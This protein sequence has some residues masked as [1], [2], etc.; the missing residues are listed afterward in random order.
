MCI[1][2]GGDDGIVGWSACFAISAVWQQVNGIMRHFFNYVNNI[3][4]YI[5]LNGAF[6]TCF[7]LL[8]TVKHFLKTL[9]YVWSYWAFIIC[10]CLSELNQYSVAVC[11]V[12]CSQQS[13]VLQIML[14]QVSNE[15]FCFQWVAMW[16]LYSYICSCIMYKGK[17]SC[18]IVNHSCVLSFKFMYDLISIVQLIVQLRICAKILIFHFRFQYWGTCVRLFCYCMAYL[19]SLLFV[20][21][22]VRECCLCLAKA[23]VDHLLISYHTLNFRSCYT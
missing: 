20:S 21:H 16:S 17:K 10:S 6:E 7:A 11:R 5:Y 1:V 3:H 18:V 14:K 12:S 15:S 9:W 4:T 23:S 22:N 8:Q 19:R 13:F 2:W